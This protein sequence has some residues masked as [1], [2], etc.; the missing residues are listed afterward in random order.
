MFTMFTIITRH[1]PEI[2]VLLSQAIAVS[3]PVEYKLDV[4]HLPFSLY[5]FIGSVLLRGEN[6][7]A[8]DKIHEILM[9][10]IKAR[11]NLNREAHFYLNLGMTSTPLTFSKEPTLFVQSPRLLS[12]SPCVVFGK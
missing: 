9:Y 11:I 3:N 7:T 1:M 2:I 4:C 5:L 8:L 6:Q 10:L 12:S